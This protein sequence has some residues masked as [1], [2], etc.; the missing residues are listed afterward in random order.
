MKTAQELLLDWLNV[1]LN[2]ASFS[3]LRER[4]E[5]FESGVPKIFIHLAFSQ[6]IRHTGKSLLDANTR[7]QAE[8]FSHH[9]GWDLREWTTDQV[10]RAALLLSL[11][12]GAD[13][14]DAVLELHQT[15]DMGEHVAL[16]RSLFMLPDARSLRHIA[17]EGLRSNMRNVFQATSQRNPY[18]AEFCDDI[19]WNQMV[20]KCIFQDL[21]LRGIYGLDRR[22]NGEL[23]RILLELSEERRAAG[24]PLTEEI[25]RCV[26]SA[27]HEKGT[28]KR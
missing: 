26:D 17:R 25:W 22:R 27:A 21:P 3:W 7:E 19:A 2:P 6:A 4:C 12:H 9:P 16:V 11:P 14:I 10:A 13:T 28:W 15:A 5:G 20:V 23:S 8:A 18:P 1:R 24:R